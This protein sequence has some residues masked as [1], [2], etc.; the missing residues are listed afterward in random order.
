MVKKITLKCV[1]IDDMKTE[2]ELK[3][4]DEQSTLYALECLIGEV[5]PFQG[6]F[7]LKY[8]S[9]MKSLEDRPTK[10]LKKAGITN[11]TVII[12]EP[13]THEAGLLKPTESLPDVPLLR[14][15]SSK[16]R[17]SAPFLYDYRLDDNEITLDGWEDAK[18]EY[19]DEKDDIAD[20]LPFVS[21]PPLIQRQPSWVVM[22]D[23]EIGDK[24]KELMEEVSQI[25]ELTNDETAKLLRHFDWDKNV[26]FERYAED[27]EKTLDEAGIERDEKSAKSGEKKDEAKGPNKEKRCGI[28]YDPDDSDEEEDE[29]PEEFFALDC[30]H[31]FCSLCWQGW[32]EAKFEE[33]PECIFT[34][35]MKPKCGEVV[36]TSF[37]LKMVDKEKGAKI[38]QYVA[39]AFVSQNAFVKWC[40]AKNCGRAIEYKKKGMRTVKCVCGH[41]FCFGCGGENHDPAPCKIVL[42][43]NK[44][45]NSESS[46][47]EWIEKNKS[48]KDVKN[49]TKCHIVIEKNQGCKHMTCK[50]CK[51]E[52]CW[53]CYQNWR[54]HNETICIEYQKNKNTGLE[55]EKKENLGDESGDAFRRYQF[56]YTRFD[57]HAQAIVHAEKIRQETQ[58]RMDKL[59][60]ISGEGQHQVQFLLD[61]T[62][63]IIDCRSLLKWSYPWCYFL[64]EDSNLYRLFKGHQEMLEKFTEE[65]HE[66]T[67]KPIETQMEGSTRKDIVDKTRVVEKYRENIVE[68]A[69][70]NH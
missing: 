15:D 69:R 32:L 60:Q 57:N 26:A 45:N 34:K 8:A 52:F 44:K 67:E 13:K 58:E 40:P 19:D 51:H 56:Y 31:T 22:G 11:S 38:E 33:G 48:E 21:P 25:L 3:G 14:C 23:S 20:P 28:C 36:P 1:A 24:E 65:L 49:C 41:S 35:C 16:R 47:F 70:S 66:L 12:F 9:N 61:A 62:N 4:L 50:N 30:G 27:P 68:F 39:N 6:P 59:Q 2:Y 42:D 54:G 17:N 53:L 29:E 43:W 64:K 55:R 5:V 7:Y 10:S 37:Y 18:E 46:I 63:T